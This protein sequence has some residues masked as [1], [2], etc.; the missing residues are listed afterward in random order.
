M[1]ADDPA[2]SARDGKKRNRPLRVELHGEFLAGHSFSNINEQLALHLI[3]DDRFELTLRR[4]RGVCRH[5]TPDE[6]LP[7][8]ERLRPLLDGV[9][10]Q[11]P[12]VTIRHAF[13]PCWEPP[14]GRWVHIQPW[15]YGPLPVEWVAPLRERVDE[16]WVMSHYVRRLYEFSG[17]PADKIHRIPWG[18]DPAIFHPAAPKPPLPKSFAFLFVGAPV[19]R[20]GLDRVLE[21]YL[22]EFGPDE[23]VC[24]VI[25]DTGA[26]SF[27]GYLKRDQ[28]LAE[29]RR[30]DNPVIVYLAD[31]LAPTQLAGLYTTCDCLVAPYRGEGFCLPVLEAMACGTPAIV[32]S[33]GPTDDFTF[34]ESA[35]LLPSQTVPIQV[36]TNPAAWEMTG[37]RL[38][39][40]PT[41]LSV[42]KEDIRAAMRQA[43]GDRAL[44]ARRGEMA[45]QAVRDYT[46]ANTVDAMKSRL[47]AMAP[48]E[49]DNRAC[50]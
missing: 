50:P 19:R 12:D 5:S 41:E 46:W 10:S 32:P 7:N 8:V 42:Q 37:W 31:E 34:A 22:T 49:R 17:V 1:S 28:L 48:G 45:C 36:E 35:F 33:G 18:V 40:T 26:R 25:K 30:P 13:P 29:S 20:K 27:Y 4:V 15:E 2:C 14:A 38:I 16:I 23:D 24:L 3:E 11:T 44:T 6:Q 21:A 47:L 39:G 9:P 43:F